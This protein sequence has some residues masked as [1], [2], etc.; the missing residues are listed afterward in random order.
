MPSARK[1]T[2]ALPVR[3][4]AVYI[5]QCIQ[6]ILSQTIQDFELII[7]ENASTDNTLEVIQS[8][9]DNRIK[10]ISTEENLTIEQNWSRILNIPKGEFLTIIGHDDFFEPDYLETMDALIL[11]NPKSSLYQTHFSFVDSN[12]NFV[13]NCHPMKT[14]YSAADAIATFMQGGIDLMGTGF[15]MRSKD[16][17]A[18]GGIPPHSSLLFSDMELFISLA[19]KGGLS[20]ADKNCFNYRIH[21]NSTTSSS[22]NKAYYNGFERLV[23][24]LVQLKKAEPHYASVIE[25]EGESFM[26]KYGQTIVH[27]ILKTNK[28]IR[29]TSG[30][31]K[32][33]EQLNQTGT[34][35]I[36]RPYRATDNGK[37]KLAQTIDDNFLLHQLYL[38]FRKIYKKPVFS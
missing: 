36:G 24:Y 18:V 4:G 3:N 15:M 12:G 34:E 38:L 1:Y 17:D 7:L 2:I 16:Y 31:R 5:Y 23:S 28:A 37:I 22:S 14:H 32:T 26:H 6:S 13:R 9:D 19:I 11:Q 10:I 33:I 29:Q 21:Q 8:F 27:K 20:V 30:V 35:L 25:K